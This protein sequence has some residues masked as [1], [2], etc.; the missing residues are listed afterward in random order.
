MIQKMEIQ[1]RKID[2]SRVY[3]HTESESKSEA[4]RPKWRKAKQARAGQGKPGQA[5][6]GQAKASQAKLGQAK[7]MSIVRWMKKTLWKTHTKRLNECKMIVFRCWK[8]SRCAPGKR[9]LFRF[10]IPR[11]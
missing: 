6:P 5:K 11:K 2:S 4:M 10:A 3:T 9:K 1:S 8:R 7:Q